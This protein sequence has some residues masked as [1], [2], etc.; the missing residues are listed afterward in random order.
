MELVVVQVCHYNL[1]GSVM[2]HKVTQREKID[3]HFASYIRYFL[4]IDV[5]FEA[6]K[7][8]KWLK[9]I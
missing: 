5:L 2:F 8:N 6:C 1:N 9:K 3:C 4:I 7:V